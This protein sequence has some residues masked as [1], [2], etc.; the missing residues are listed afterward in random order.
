[1][2]FSKLYR[3]WSKF[4]ISTIF[5]YHHTRSI[6]KFEASIGRFP[7]GRLNQ[8]QVIQY[9]VCS[10]ISQSRLTNLATLSIE[11]Q[12]ADNSNFDKLIKEFADT[13]A[14]KVKFYFFLI[15]GYIFIKFHYI[16]CFVSYGSE[17]CQGVLEKNLCQQRCIVDHSLVLI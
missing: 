6:S 4:H 16:P 11:N 9:Y 17:C 2:L 5:K 8:L 1:M 14:R 10:T 7:L 13:K 12:I 15:N 3:H